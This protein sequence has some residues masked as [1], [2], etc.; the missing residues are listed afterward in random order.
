MQIFLKDIILYQKEPNHCLLR[1]LQCL[2]QE[3]YLSLICSFQVLRRK[4]YRELELP[5]CHT[6][7]ANLVSFLQILAVGLHTSLG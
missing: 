3:V 5:S 7:I 6:K 2:A 1:P 4:A